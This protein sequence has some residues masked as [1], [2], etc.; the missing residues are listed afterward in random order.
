[1]ILFKIKVKFNKNE[2]KRRKKT[3]LAVTNN[4]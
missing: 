2:P 1:M 3:C 4:F